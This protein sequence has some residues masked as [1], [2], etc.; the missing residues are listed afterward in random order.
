MD[1]VGDDL[2]TD[3]AGGERREDDEE[4]GGDE[5]HGNGDEDQ[6]KEPDD[7][8]QPTESHSLSL[9]LSTQHHRSGRIWQETAV[10]VPEMI[11]RMR[12][13]SACAFV[14]L[15]RALESMVYDPRL[16]QKLWD[17][18]IYRGVGQ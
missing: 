4:E 18:V 10:D 14:T 13:N 12:T 1:E 11:V 17:F 2:H 9:A 7:G 5:G 6:D 8:P 15:Q 16:S 3:A